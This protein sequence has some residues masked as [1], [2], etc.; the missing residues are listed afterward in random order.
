MMQENILEG[1]RQYELTRWGPGSEE[2]RPLSPRIQVQVSGGKRE[3]GV[4]GR[5]PVH[6]R[7]C[8][9]CNVHP[10]H[11]RDTIL[12]H[13]LEYKYLSLYVLYSRLNIY[14]VVLYFSPFIISIQYCRLILLQH[15]SL[16]INLA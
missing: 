10:G 11:E 7:S 1:W 14:L 13:F 16:S 8:E 15:L 6:S 4:R 5:G 9:M 3:G 2:G 12:R